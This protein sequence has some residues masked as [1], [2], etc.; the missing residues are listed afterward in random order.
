MSPVYT[1]CHALVMRLGAWR[2]ASQTE[3][4]RALRTARIQHAM[5]ANIL[6]AVPETQLVNARDR[7]HALIMEVGA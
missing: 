2:N 7:L 5:G 4:E 6:R 3:E 1:Q